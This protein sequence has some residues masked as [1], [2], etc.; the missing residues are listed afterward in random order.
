MTL[1]EENRQLK[2]VIII[3]MILLALL[4][5]AMDKAEA[6]EDANFRHA[7]GNTKLYGSAKSPDPLVLRWVVNKERTIC[8][9]VIFAHDRLHI[10]DPFICSNGRPDYNK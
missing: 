6:H 7:T 3:L 9:D 2:F 5:V 10:T 8:I 1:K 4:F